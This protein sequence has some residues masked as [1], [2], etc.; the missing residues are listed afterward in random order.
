MIG[1]VIPNMPKDE[2]IRTKAMGQRTLGNVSINCEEQGRDDCL[3]Y[4]VS[5]RHMTRTVSEEYG[6]SPRLRDKPW[7]EVLVT[8]LEEFSITSTNH[9]LRH[10][11]LVGKTFHR[12]CFPITIIFPVCRMEEYFTSYFYTYH[13]II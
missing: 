6:N 3:V 9:I 5:F 4:Q 1:I 7:T 2:E 10:R 12:G 11:I 13:L 8:I